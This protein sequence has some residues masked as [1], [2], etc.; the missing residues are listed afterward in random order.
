MA[1]RRKKGKGR[2]RRLRKNKQTEGSVAKRP[3]WR[4]RFAKVKPVG[5]HGP[6]SGEQA[7]YVAPG[8]FDGAGEGGDDSEA[9]ARDPTW[10]IA[11]VFFLVNLACVILGTELG[12]LSPFAAGYTNNDWADH[13]TEYCPGFIPSFSKD[14]PKCWIEQD[15]P[16]ITMNGNLVRTVYRP[17]ALSLP[18]PHRSDP[19]TRLSQ[20]AASS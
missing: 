6:I 16:T 19:V 1:K 13:R 17:T 3:K 15:G 20:R 2:R 8:L 14:P 9:E 18:P 4:K 11:R 5:G 10:A 7:D 12:P